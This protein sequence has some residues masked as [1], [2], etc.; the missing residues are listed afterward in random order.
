[1]TLDDWITGWCALADSEFVRMIKHSP[2][3][4]VA[5]WKTEPVYSVVLYSVVLS[6]ENV[7]ELGDRDNDQ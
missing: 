6:I 1:M 7:W 5:M 4:D 3:P 2:P